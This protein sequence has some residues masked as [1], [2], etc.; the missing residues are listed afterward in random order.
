[1][2][3]VN[4]INRLWRKAPSLWQRGEAEQGSIRHSRG[5][6]PVADKMESRLTAL[7]AF[8]QEMWT[9]ALGDFQSLIRHGRRGLRLHLGGD[10]NYS[11]LA[12]QEAGQRAVKNI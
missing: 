12:L 11:L 8:P 9:Q 7:G 4:F 2:A 10:F 3:Q 5:W 1:M 6:L